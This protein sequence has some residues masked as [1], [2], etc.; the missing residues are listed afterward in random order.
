MSRLHSFL[1]FLRSSIAR[2]RRV[3]FIV[4]L[5]LNF[6]SSVSVAPFLFQWDRSSACDLLPLNYFF[7]TF[8]FFFLY[9][10]T[11][12]IYSFIL[13]KAVMCSQRL[14]HVATDLKR[15]S[16][17]ETRNVSRENKKNK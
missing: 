13:V 2:Q 15:L 6:L 5:S 8:P 1:T 10:L 14:S 16:L 9:S 4:F 11:F 12:R 3:T 7:T 17:S